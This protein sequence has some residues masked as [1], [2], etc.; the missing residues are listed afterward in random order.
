MSAGSWFRHCSS[1][2]SA[3]WTRMMAIPSGSGSVTGPQI[4]VTSAPCWRSVSAIVMPC[5]PE[6]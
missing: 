4:S 5:F 1:I 3:V 6:E 2:C